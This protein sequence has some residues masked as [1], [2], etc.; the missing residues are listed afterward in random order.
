MYFI[1]DLK[2]AGKSLRKKMNLRGQDMRMYSSWCNV[3]LVAEKFQ[4]GFDQPLLHSMY[5][6]K[7]LQGQRA[8]QT[9]STKSDSPG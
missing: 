6:D 3:L 8:V 9:L 2:M 4:T 1:G 7:K 5:V